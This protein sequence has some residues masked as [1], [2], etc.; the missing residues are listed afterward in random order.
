MNCLALDGIHPRPV[1][2]VRVL[3]LRSYR[4]SVESG[5]RRWV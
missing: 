5:L 2:I 3:A 4:M 1:G